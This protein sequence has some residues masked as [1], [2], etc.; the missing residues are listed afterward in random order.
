MTK[1][2]LMFQM[3]K[4]KENA[5]RAVCKTVGVTPIA[6][7]YKDY[8]QKLGTL[9]GVQGFTKTKLLYTGSAFPAEMLV[10]SGMD[11]AEVD[12]FLAK[13]K[14]TGA[15]GIALKAIVTAHN[16][17]WTADELF[18]ELMREHMSYPLNRN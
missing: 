1:V 15:A 13:Y 9:A 14:K 12:E 3:E 18:K 8:G 6:V 17:F 5:L 16:V 10:F 7:A 11:S 2:I 4:S